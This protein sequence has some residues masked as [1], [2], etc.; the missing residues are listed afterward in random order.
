[1]HHRS[2]A[3]IPQRVIDWWRNR[4]KENTGSRGADDAGESDDITSL[5][6]RATDIGGRAKNVVGG[7]QSRGKDAVEELNRRRQ[8]ETDP[9]SSDSQ[10]TAAG[11]GERARGAASS[12]ATLARSAVTKASDMRTGSGAD[13]VEGATATSSPPE[14]ATEGPTIGSASGSAERETPHDSSS[15]AW[16]STAGVL[17]PELSSPSNFIKAEQSPASQSAQDTGDPDTTPGDRAAAT[18]DVDTTAQVAGNAEEGTRNEAASAATQAR[19]N[20]TDEEPLLQAPDDPIGDSRDR[21]PG[22]ESAETSSEPFAYASSPDSESRDR[23]E[24]TGTGGSPAATAP[25]PVSSSARKLSFARRGTG[26]TTATPTQDRSSEPDDAAETGASGSVSTPA[27]VGDDGLPIYFD[28][29]D[30]TESAAQSSDRAGLRT[31][32]N[33]PLAAGQSHGGAARTAEP[34]GS[35]REHPALGAHT[36]DGSSI[37]ELEAEAPGDDPTF[38]SQS[39]TLSGDAYRSTAAPEAV[40]PDSDDTG[41][42]RRP[43]P[44]SSIPDF[45]TDADSPTRIIESPIDSGDTSERNTSEEFGSIVSGDP[46]DERPAGSGVTIS[47]PTSRVPG[48]AEPVPDPASGKARAGGETGRRGT[49]GLGAAES[50]TSAGAGSFEDVEVADVASSDDPGTGMQASDAVT[51]QD[52]AGAVD[53]SD[54]DGTS[55]AITRDA[56]RTN[57]GATSPSTSQGRSRRRTRSKS[58]ERPRR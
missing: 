22:T 38:H 50:G 8:G 41:D 4:S 28:T 40:V 10:Q 11:I 18:P 56:A 48:N 34:A 24:P 19:T 31:T 57:D 49:S 13:T 2:P 3:K 33:D 32:A 17:D 47:E 45:A 44:G 16:A 36:D 53:T 15:V 35:S 42:V 12:A 26:P 54:P 37:T 14:Q 52:A 23:D 58:D 27:P 55:R 21:T 6:D 5:R 39:T 43:K 1:M 46:G 7:I 29:D 51:Q 25:S 9:G 30:G 20:T